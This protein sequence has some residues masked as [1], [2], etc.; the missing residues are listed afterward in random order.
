MNKQ[1]LVAALIAL[2]GCEGMEE[3]T[4]NN[5][6][7]SA[8]GGS[9]TPASVTINPATVTEG[10]DTEAVVSLSIS[11]KL[12]KDVSVYLEFIDQSAI[13][14]EDYAPPESILIINRGELSKNLTI[15]ILDDNIDESDKTF[16]VRIENIEGAS[17]ASSKQEA[18]IT[19]RDNE[20]EPQLS[21]SNTLRIV[22]ETD[23]VIHYTATLD[24]LSAFDIE[25]TYSLSGTA[26]KDL[27]YIDSTNGRLIIK[28][29]E[30]SGEIDLTILEDQISEGGETIVLHLEDPLYASLDGE[31][32]GSTIIINGDVLINDTGVT[33]WRD[34]SSDS[35][36][37]AP[38]NYPNQDAD[39]GR[40]VTN[41]FNGDGYAG[42]SYTKMD[43]S[44]NSL[45]YNSTNYECVKD[46]TTGLIWEIKREDF[47]LDTLLPTEDNNRP[48]TTTNYRAAN[49][50]YTWHTENIENSGRSTGSENDR[51][52]NGWFFD[53]DGYCAY[54]EEELPRPHILRCNSLAYE[55][56]VNY[57]GLCGSKRW[58]TPTALE[59][60]SIMNYEI[61]N[62]K[63]SGVF[64]EQEVFNNVKAG[65]YLSSTPA[66]ELD[67]SVWCLN[68]E[69]GL[70]ELCHKGGLNYL[71]LVSNA[72]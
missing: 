31:S 67:A 35:L 17:P 14:G 22:D 51:F 57:Y 62:R 3:E 11:K 9:T 32:D 20:S 69:T 58:R 15:P 36:V 50:K 16:L 37:I 30:S 34:E 65:N 4:E 8:G 25:V 39:F 70:T 40:D 41:P 24:H 43:G 68:T 7:S 19:I 61:D 63:S 45:P 42:F 60:K 18:L 56:D 38:D 71:R 28:A 53:A 33:K 46:N 48:G 72:E 13:T 5:N 23:S 49:Y 26:A 29:K 52:N 47:D 44:G 21:I 2:T 1:W 6:T 59:L 66:S 10:R 54:I 27:D 64:M 55:N 12:D